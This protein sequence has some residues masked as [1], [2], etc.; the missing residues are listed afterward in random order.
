MK[1]NTHFF[2]ARMGCGGCILSN[3]L[4]GTFLPLFNWLAHTNF[5]FHNTLWE[6]PITL[7]GGI[8]VWCSY[9]HYYEGHPEDEAKLDY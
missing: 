5:Q 6:W 2:L 9:A 7:T 3:C 4:V 1:L 8:I